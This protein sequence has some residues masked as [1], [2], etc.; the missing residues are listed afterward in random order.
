MLQ[1]VFENP[2]VRAAG[3]AAVLVLV[4]VLVYMLST[5][6]IPLFFAFLVAYMF[7]PAVG[8]LERRKLPH[9]TA[10]VVLVVAIIL[11]FFSFPL[12]VVPGMYNEAQRLIDGATQDMDNEWLDRVLDRLPLETLVNQ[13]GWMPKGEE[14]FDERAVFAQKIGELIRDHAGA[15]LRSYAQDISGAGRSAGVSAAAFFVSLGNNVLRLVLFIGN[16]ALFAFVAIY[17]LKDYR[18]IITGINELIPPRHREGVAVIMRRID[19]QLQA[20]LRGQVTV[21]FCLAAMY[22]TGLK[23]SGVPFAVPLALFGGFASFVPYMGLVLTIGPALLLCVLAHGLG[24]APGG[25][26]ATFVLAQTVE[27]YFLTPKIVGSKVG[28]SPVWVILAIMVFSSTLGFL[29]LLLAVPIAAVL[30]VLVSEGVA[31]YKRSPLFEAPAR[32]TTDS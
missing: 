1:P 6:L 10:V 17:L 31:Y 2:W 15:F 18:R 8:A 32:E 23:L 7:Q 30:K 5:V 28:L 22:A 21:C 12:V 27:G 3:L 24:W 11:I 13:L 25:V 16:F 29:G 9:T 26:V 20:Y 19:E 14:E 4:A